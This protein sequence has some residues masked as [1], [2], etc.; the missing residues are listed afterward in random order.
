[1]VFR[2]AGLWH[3]DADLQLLALIF[4][5]HMTTSIRFGLAAWLLATFM[6][7][8]H[9]QTAPAPDAR[10]GKARAAECFGCHNANGISTL[11]GIPHL[12]GQERSYLESVLHDYRDGRT[13]LNL[14]MNPMAQP[15]SDRDIANIAAY[16][17]KQTRMGRAQNGKPAAK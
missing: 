16:F 10:A 13:R 1:M 8:T 6:T 9:A 7:H 5:T 17:S 12:A 14:T 15:L 11:P 2:D 4:N 3:R